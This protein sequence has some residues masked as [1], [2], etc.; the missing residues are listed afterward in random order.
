MINHSPHYIFVSDLP[1]GRERTRLEKKGRRSK[2]MY[3]T[4]TCVA[5]SKAQTGSS[6][7]MNACRDAIHTLNTGRQHPAAME[8]HLKGASGSLGA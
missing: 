8:K 1:L 7:Q 3:K 2:L 6:Y 4:V 5:H